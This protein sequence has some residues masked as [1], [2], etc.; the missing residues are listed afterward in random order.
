MADGYPRPEIKWRATRGQDL[1]FK[2]YDGNRLVFDSVSKDDEGEYFCRAE[3]E[4]GFDEQRVILFVNGGMILNENYLFYN[5]ICYFSRCSTCEPKS[6]SSS[7][8][9][10]D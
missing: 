4:A 9:T 3:N 10:H 1:R 5:K 8:T 2:V 7:L 6:S